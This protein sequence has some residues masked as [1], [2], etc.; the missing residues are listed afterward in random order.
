MDGGKKKIA[1]IFYC[2]IFHLRLWNLDLCKLL[3][4]GSNGASIMVGSQTGVSTRLYEEA[5]PFLLVCHYVAH[6]TNL[7]ALDVAKTPDCKVLSFKT[8]VLINS[9]SRFFLQIE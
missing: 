5:N 8:Y 3:A 7:A 9:I 4:F 6:R 1:I 2:V